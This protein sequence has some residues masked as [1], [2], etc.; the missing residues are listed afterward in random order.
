M[1]NAFAFHPLGCFYPLGIFLKPVWLRLVRVVLMNQKRNIYVCPETK[2]PL[3]CFP[4]Q[5]D[6]SYVISGR[7]R[8]E[9]GREFHI[10]DGIP[11]LTFPK[12]LT[13]AQ[14]EALD[15]YNGIAEIYDQVAGLTFRIQYVD[16]TATRREFAKLLNLTPGSR[17]L[18]LA[19]G[20][21]KDSEIIASEL[22]QTGE[23][24]LQDLSQ[25]MLLRCREKLRGVSVPV[26]FSAGNGCHLPFPDRYFDAVFSFGGLGVFSDIR[27]SLKEIV[28]VSKIG[29]KVV[30]GDESMPAW[31][32]ETEYGRILL[33]NNPLFKN[34][35][36]FEHI[37]VEARHVTV[38]WVIG[39][40]YYLIDFV[41]GDG[42]PK[43]DFDLEIPGK[44]GGTLR[45]RYCGRL[46][47]VTSE[48]YELAHKAREKSGQS[49]HVWL[50][51][52]VRRAAIRELDL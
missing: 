31:L 49:M 36:P 46:E 40:V 5:L 13:R 20:T 29:A 24:Y 38:R 47:G 10:Q 34:P 7:L 27:R 9:T 4:D 44:R 26:E 28:R 33:N 19:C 50:D 51:E 3:Q 52:A 43:A 11:D 1:S 6:G 12:E 8:S 32:Y 39:G 22:D 23:L 25:P 42:E 16:E 15:Y 35:V 45:T 21:G 41:V 37:P 48:T 30:V 14:Q 18:E 17:V 2:K